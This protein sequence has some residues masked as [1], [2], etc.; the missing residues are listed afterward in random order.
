MTTSEVEMRRSDL[1]GIL[2]VLSLALALLLAI[3]LLSGGNSC[4]AKC[5]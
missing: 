1:I 2:V 5:A 3:A 4:G